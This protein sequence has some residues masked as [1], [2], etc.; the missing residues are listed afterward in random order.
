MCKYVHE[1][2]GCTNIGPLH[3]KGTALNLYLQ[4]VALIA[5]ET[6]IFKSNANMQDVSKPDHHTC[7]EIFCIFY[8][9]LK[10][11]H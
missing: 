4:I 2:A 9:D 8:F 10:I 5:P 1:V 6:Y 3:P 7:F 11:T